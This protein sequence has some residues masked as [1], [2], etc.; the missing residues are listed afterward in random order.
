[1]RRV[2]LIL[3]LLTCSPVLPA[4]EED[5]DGGVPAEAQEQ[6]Q[7]LTVLFAQARSDAV[8]AWREEARKQAEAREA[9]GTVKAMRMF[10]MDPI[11]KEFLPRFQEAAAKHAGSEGAVPFLIWVVSNAQNDR[12]ALKAALDTL[13]SSHLESAQLT[14]VA[15]RL[16]GLASVVGAERSAELLAL[17]IEKSPHADVQAQALL[18]RG[19]QVFE[20]EET[21]EPEREAAKVDLRR[22]SELAQSPGIAGRARGILFEQEHLQVGMVAPDIE[23]ADLDGVSFKLS[24]YRG[25]VIMLDFWGDW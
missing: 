6:Y 9:G 1:M 8:A 5:K 25:K 18:S 4:Q 23:G 21:S 12:E 20:A 19:E 2:L 11:V 10:S 14:A 24:D 16:G 3:A 15:A 13:I 7:K 22:A 17:L